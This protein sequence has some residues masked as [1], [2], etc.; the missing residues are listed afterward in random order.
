[1]HIYLLS[2]G[3]AAVVS[4][5]ERVLAAGSTAL[6]NC[7][8][9]AEMRLIIAVPMPGGDLEIRIFRCSDCNH[10]LRLTVWH[11]DLSAA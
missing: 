5:L 6:P 4:R 9:S 8:C 11:G 7:R 10:E 3:M 1:M 2:L